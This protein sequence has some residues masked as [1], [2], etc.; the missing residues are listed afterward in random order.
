MD[1]GTGIG[2]GIYIPRRDGRYTPTGSEDFSL[3][4]ICLLGGALASFSLSLSTERKQPN[5]G[6]KDGTRTGIG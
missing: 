5:D 4:C 3:Y 2:I 1:Y 6:N